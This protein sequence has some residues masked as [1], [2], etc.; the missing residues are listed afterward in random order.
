MPKLALDNHQIG[1]NFTYKAARIED[2]GA[3]EYTLVTIAVDVTGSTYLFA[4]ELHDMLTA[5]IESCRRSP[6]SDN[7]LVRVIIFSS[8][9]GIRE[10]HGFKPLSDIDPA[11]DYP[12]FRPSGGTP[13]CDA[14]FSGVPPEGRKAG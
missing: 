10:L 4:Q 1:G 11:Q 12:A 3:T 9:V 8:A 7:L 6:R 5:A 14:T 13:L 2:L